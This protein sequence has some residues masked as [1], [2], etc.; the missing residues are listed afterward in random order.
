M[1]YYVSSKISGKEIFQLEHD[2]IVN[3]N[4]EDGIGEYFVASGFGHPKLPVI[5]NKSEFKRFS[6]GL[7]PTWVKDVETAKKLSIN[8]LNAVG[9][10]LTEK[11]SYRGAVKAGNFCIIPVNGFYEWHTHSNGNKYPFFIYP[12]QDSLF[13]MAGLYDEWTNPSLNEKQ[14]TF[15]IVTTEANERMKWI[16]NSKMRM[17]AILTTEEAK[18]WLSNDIAFSEK[19][20]L[21]N[22]FEVELMADHSISKLITSRKENPNTEAVVQP[23][24]YPELMAS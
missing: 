20:K 3:W 22:P 2:F 17:P 21:L 15:T 7:I 13:L 1:C 9:E 19:Q 4:E 8:T 16:H 6:W 5:T 12:K 14:R 24:D 10:T 11:P 18:L 23:F